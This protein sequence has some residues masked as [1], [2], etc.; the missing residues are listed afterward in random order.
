MGEAFSGLCGTRE[1]VVRFFLKIWMSEEAEESLQWVRK[2]PSDPQGTFF[3]DH[4]FVLSAT[5]AGNIRRC[6]VCHSSRDEAAKHTL[7]VENTAT[8]GFRWKECS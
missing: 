2:A 8:V 7:L 3:H 6:L 4:L 5:K 1:H